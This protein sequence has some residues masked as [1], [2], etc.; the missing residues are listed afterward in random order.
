M[1]SIQE[2]FATVAAWVIRAVLLT[3]GL[4]FTLSL[5][6]S[7]L[8]IGMVAV[9]AALLT[10]RR[11]SLGAF[12]VHRGPAWGRFGPRPGAGFARRPGGAA[13]RDDDVVDAVVREVPDH[14]ARI[15]GSP[16]R[17]PGAPH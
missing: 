8:V 2:F 1:R 3:V 4:V 9:G 10:G 14:S 17:P 12:R 6:I 11:P 5:L 7:A 16:E 15:D 13:R